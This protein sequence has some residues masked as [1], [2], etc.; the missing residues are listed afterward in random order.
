[1][2]KPGP[3]NLASCEGS[4]TAVVKTGILFRSAL[5]SAQ[6]LAGAGPGSMYSIPPNFQLQ[7]FSSFSQSERA[8]TV[9]FAYVMVS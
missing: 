1:M 3:S 9:W 2:S 8:P 7:R 5:S 6:R 4:A